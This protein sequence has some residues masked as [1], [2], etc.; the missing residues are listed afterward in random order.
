MFHIHIL[1]RFL[2]FFSIIK[3]LIG[4]IIDTSTPQNIAIPCI[5]KHGSG[6]FLSPH[7]YLKTCL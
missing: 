1:L 6:M 3:F 2:K 5:L 7:Q 4:V